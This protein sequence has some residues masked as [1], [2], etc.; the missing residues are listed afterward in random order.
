MNLQKID[1]EMQHIRNIREVKE[2]KQKCDDFK[3]GDE[4]GLYFGGGTLVGYVESIEEDGTI[5]CSNK[6]K[7]GNGF[8]GN[9]LPEL[10][11]LYHIRKDRGMFKTDEGVM[12]KEGEFF[13]CVGKQGD[14]IERIAAPSN[15]LHGYRNFYRK[16]DAEKYILNK[17]IKQ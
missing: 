8:S 7:G 5:Y 15:E 1:A 13:Y 17:K 11:G 6:I 10:G 9:W 14:I 16:K 2:Y 12:L 3:I 4:V